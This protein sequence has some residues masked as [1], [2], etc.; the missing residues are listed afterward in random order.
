[1]SSGSAR[2]SEEVRRS[3]LLGPTSH[4]RAL[5]FIALT[6]LVASARSACWPVA[7]LVHPLPDPPVESPRAPVVLVHGFLGHP[8]MFRP[9]QRRL[10]DAGFGRVARV[11]YPSTRSTLDAIVARIEQVAAP[12]A[13]RWGPVDLVGHSLGAV[14]CRAWIKLFGGARHV[15]RFV[16]L[17]GPHAGTSLHRMVPPRL[18][19]V[20]DP[21]GPWV[22]RLSE[23]PEPVPTTVIR[24][25]YDHQVVPPLRAALPGVREIVLTGY[26][27]N[28]LLWSRTA[29]EAVIEV[30]TEPIVP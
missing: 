21:A 16:S 4:L 30:L 14:A 17:G 26:G 1:M 23:G 28:G 13:D 24:S 5:P 7:R 20:L 11:G 6:E 9:L 19:E 25:R 12:L 10:Y 3:R 15:A 8:D 29:H 18:A 2:E 27:H 22:R